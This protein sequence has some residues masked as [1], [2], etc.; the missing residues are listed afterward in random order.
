[1][2]VY[3]CVCVCVCVITKKAQQILCYYK[4]ILSIL[5]VFKIF[6]VCF[7]KYNFNRS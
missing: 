4:F 5:E 1:M 7:Y 2:S 3:K 6:F